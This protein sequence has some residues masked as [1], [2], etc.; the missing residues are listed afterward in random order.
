[1]I[2][3]AGQSSGFVTIPVSEDDVYIDTHTVTNSIV[4]QPAAP[5]T[6]TW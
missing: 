1:M 6:R 4:S 2:V 3:T 5:S